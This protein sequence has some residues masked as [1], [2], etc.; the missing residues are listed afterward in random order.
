[1][2]NFIKSN[3]SL[4]LLFL[5]TIITAFMAIPSFISFFIHIIN[6]VLLI[7][8][9]YVIKHPTKKDSIS[10][11]ILILISTGLCALTTPP[12]MF[13]L[14]MQIINFAIIMIMWWV[15]EKETVNER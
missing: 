3:H 9:R 13:A 8:A 6:F 7:G 10:A 4:S 11:A 15:A 5:S 1:M 12:S 14:I 2:L